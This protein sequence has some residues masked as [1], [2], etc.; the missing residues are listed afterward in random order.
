M[1]QLYDLRENIFRHQ[2]EP[3][4]WCLSNA[5]EMK[6]ICLEIRSAANNGTIA[7]ESAGEPGEE[8]ELNQNYAYN[9]EEFVT[10]KLDSENDL[11]WIDLI[12]NIETG[13]DEEKASPVHMHVCPI[14]SLKRQL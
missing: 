6:E 1:Q 8:S 3:C 12:C 9:V 7:D 5:V 13:R 2:E 11:F 4:Q 10:A 14:C